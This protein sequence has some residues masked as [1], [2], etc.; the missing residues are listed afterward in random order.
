MAEFYFRQC[1]KCNGDVFVDH[2]PLE[3]WAEK[4]IQCGFRKYL[5][6]LDGTNS[7]LSVDPGE[8]YAD[9]TVN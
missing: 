3:G 8:G 2:D 6:E 7:G 5:N 4:C 9:S 1:P